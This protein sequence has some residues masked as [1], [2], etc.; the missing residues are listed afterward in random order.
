MKK[1][2]CFIAVLGIFASMNLLQS[3]SSDSDGTIYAN[4]LV[5]VKPNADNTEVYLQLDDNT[6]LYPVNMK[7]SPFGKKE[8]RALM[9]YSKSE[10]YVGPYTYGVNVNWIDSILTKTTAPNFS[11]QENLEKYGADEVEIIN[12]WVTIAEDGYLTLR[13]RT[14]WGARA[15]HKVNLVYRTDINNP[16][17]VTF[18]HN[19]NG[20][21]SGALGDG[22][23]A[24]KLDELPDTKGETVELTLQW[25]SYTGSK[26]AKFKYCTRQATNVL[27]SDKLERIGSQNIE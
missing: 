25:K 17:T 11:E 3:C 19:A 4:A 6:T 14:Y 26:S 21:K 20:D 1:I 18:Y 22:L 8:V 5:T 16:Y 24:F 9:N 15:T 27:S 7:T 13:F 23:V 2:F 12:D 10:G